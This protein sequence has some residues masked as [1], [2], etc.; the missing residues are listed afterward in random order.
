L[1]IATAVSY[2]YAVSVIVIQA[3]TLLSITCTH[4]DGSK[5]NDRCNIE[6]IRMIIWRFLDLDVFG[7]ASIS[8]I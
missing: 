8:A 1:N 2:Q 5:I 4:S 7:I 6:L 3:S